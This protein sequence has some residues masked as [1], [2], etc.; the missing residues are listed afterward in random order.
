[1]RGGLRAMR[2]DRLTACAASD[3]AANV[4]AADAGAP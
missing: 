1:V 2:A 3:T 4:I